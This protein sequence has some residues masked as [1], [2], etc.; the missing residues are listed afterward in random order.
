VQLTSPQISKLLLK[1]FSSP[2]QKIIDAIPRLD[3]FA[4]RPAEGSVDKFFQTLTDLSDYYL[5]HQN[6]NLFPGDKA[7]QNEEFGEAMRIISA[8]LGEGQVV[9]AGFTRIRG[10]NGNKLRKA[11]L[12]MARELDDF[13]PPDLFYTGISGP[14]KGYEYTPIC[15]NKKSFVEKHGR[16]MQVSQG[17]DA[18]FWQ[19]IS[20]DELE[21]DADSLSISG[22][23][24]EAGSRGLAYVCGQ[25]GGQKMIVGFTNEISGG[26]GD[27][28]A[29]PLMD[30]IM[31]MIWEKHPGYNGK[32]R[33]RRRARQ[34]SD[35]RHRRGLRQ[36]G[37]RHPVQLITG[38]SER[39]QAG[40]ALAPDRHGEHAALRAGQ[41]CGRH[42]RGP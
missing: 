14:F 17:H 13:N 26:D 24:I 27:S 40:R 38:A 11:L 39:E 1:A 28:R 22:K 31:K 32:R 19:C 18:P 35:G 15:V 25:F 20:D 30:K 4:G 5:F 9:V 37:R 6:M 16:V 3:Y 36:S 41:D 29:Y 10:N 21:T 34:P 33:H 7:T 23:S 12:N 8:M 42:S 2:L